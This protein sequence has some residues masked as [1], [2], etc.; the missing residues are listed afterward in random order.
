M[1]SIIENKKEDR[2]I[3]QKFIL[4]TILSGIFG[5][6]LGF[7]G[8]YIDRERLYSMSISISVVMVFL[9]PAI[10][11]ILDVTLLSIGFLLIRKARKKLSLWDEE[12]EAFTKIIEHKVDLSLFFVSILM[13]LEFMFLPIGMGLVAR[14][15]NLLA[16]QSV[17][18]SMIVIFCFIVGI[19]GV[20]ICQKFGV[21]LIKEMN[22]EKRGNIFDTRFVDK[23]EASCDEA[24]KM[25][26]YKSAYKSY[27]SVNIACILLWTIS[28]LGDMI[29]QTGLLPVVLISIIWF[30]QNLSYYLEA[31]KLER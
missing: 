13:I 6:I 23:W 20:I 3:I 22:P 15:E 24:Q 9:I 7:I 14:S 17:V 27:K 8:N 5:F 30:V 29:L 16:N 26:I 28:A 1:N 11:I 10:M 12:D 19:V 31:F 18:I 4:I 2:K 25:M 21:D